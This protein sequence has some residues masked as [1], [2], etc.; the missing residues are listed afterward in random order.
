[1]KNITYICLKGLLFAV[2]LIPIRAGYMLSFI[3]YIILRY[4]IRYR[5]KVI[6]DNLRMV[7]PDKGKKEIAGIVK[8]FYLHLSDIFIE[9]MYSMYI[10]EK[11]LRKRFR[12]V[13]PELLNRYCDEGR[14]VI[15]VAGHYANWEWG[16]GCPLYCRHKLLPVYK[17]LQSKIADR[18]F[19]DFRARFGGMPVEMSSM[20]PVIAEAAKHPVLVYLVADQTPAGNEKQWYYTSFLGLSGTPVFT[21]PEKLAQRFNAVFV[22]VNV[23]KVK[24]GYYRMEFV[25]LCEDSANT[26]ANELTDKY[27]RQME[28]VIYNKPE[29]WMWSHRRW[30]R[31]KVTA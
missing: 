25:P 3:L 22:F 5:R 28:Q 30:K 19:H 6:E 27:L 23:Q 31:R 26:A 10:P 8:K 29:H 11:T 21:G 9:L 2:T 13:N 7:F 17:K 14:H 20:K 18:L 24:R 4:I 12:Y 1:M 16:Y 15:A